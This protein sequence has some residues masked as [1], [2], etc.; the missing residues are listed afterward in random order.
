MFVVNG[1]ICIIIQNIMCKCINKTAKFWIL[2]EFKFYFHLLD[3]I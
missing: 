1:K 3:F 2:N